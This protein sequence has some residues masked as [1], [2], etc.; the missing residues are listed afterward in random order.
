MTYSRRDLLKLLGFSSVATAAQGMHFDRFF[1]KDTSPFNDVAPDRKLTAITVGGGARGNVYGR[2]A[3]DHPDQLTIIGI[4]EPIEIRRQRYVEKHKIEAQNQFTTWED[5]FKR[6]KFADFVIITTPDHLH[7]EPA[8]KALDMGYHL[9]LEKPIAQS[10]KQCN[11]ILALQKKKKAIVAVCHVLRYAPYYRKVKEVMDSGVL[12]KLVSVQHMEP[13]EHKHMSHSYVRGNWGVESKT[14]P[15]ILSKSCHDLDI[16]RWWI[17]KKCEHISSFGALSWFKPQNAPVGSTTRCTDGCAVES[18]CPYSAL[19]IYHRDRGWS[20]VMDLPEDR[21]LHGDHIM[22]RLKT[23]PY[24]RCVYHCDNDV[25]DHQVV[26]MLFPDDITASLHVE[27]FTDYA[28]RRTRVMG[29]LGCL[30]GDED[31]LRIAD[32]QTGKVQEWVTKDNAKELSGHGGGDQALVH[33][34]L[35]AVSKN[36]EAYLTSTLEASMDSHEM[37][38]LAEE[39]RK[40]FKTIKI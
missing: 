33:D 16:L 26:N 5:V 34:F 37:G 12:G 19:K 7:Y 1:L 17:G 20:Q 8:M 27:A 38:F 6:P 40:S 11:D 13:I 29:S 22:D 39:S 15:I 10:L 31:V 21:N 23:G 9:L 28:G 32:F 24:G 18:T 4:A 25:L 3:V 36:D 35:V 30:V 14:N 2:Y